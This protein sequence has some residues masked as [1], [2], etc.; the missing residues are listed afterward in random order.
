MNIFGKQFLYTEKITSFFSL[1]APP[2]YF[3]SSVLWFLDDKSRS[4]KWIVL[5]VLPMFLHVSGRN[6]INIGFV[7]AKYLYGKVKCLQCLKAFMSSFATVGIQIF[8]LF[9][10]IMFILG[11]VWT[12]VLG[13]SCMAFCV[14]SSSVF[15]FRTPFLRMEYM[16]SGVWWR[17]F[18]HLA[19]SGG[20]RG[21]GVVTGIRWIRHWLGAHC[22]GH[23]FHFI[24][25]ILF[26]ML[27]YDC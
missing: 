14:G 20:S 21:V 25:K 23:I 8:G 26:S 7:L 17:I 10:S 11:W 27:F 15:F 24:F 6:P 9:L 22:N 18:C 5:K 1:S 4:P 3:S 2:L 12:N 13:E 19:P 16:W